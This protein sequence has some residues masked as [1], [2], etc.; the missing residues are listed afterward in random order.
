MRE[1]SSKRLPNI[2]AA[3]PWR[4]EE[5]IPVPAAEEL[6]AAPAPISGPPL[7]PPEIPRASSLGPLTFFD[8]FA[9]GA[10]AVADEMAGLTRSGF[11]TMMEMTEAMLGAK[12][13]DEA[14]AIHAGFVRKSFDTMLSGSVRL[15]DIAARLAAD[16]MPA[17]R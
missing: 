15:T 17:G 12:T 3:D 10:E 5:P 6:A 13:L 2:P 14:V 11:S 4:A 7:P 16:A 8:A 1:S 9:H